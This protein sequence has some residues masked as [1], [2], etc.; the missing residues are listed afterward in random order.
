VGHLKNGIRLSGGRVAK[1]PRITSSA[2][3]STVDL[4]GVGKNAANPIQ[5]S[6]G[7]DKEVPTTTAY[8][9]A[10]EEATADPPAFPTAVASPTQSVPGSQQLGQVPKTTTLAASETT[11]DPPAFQTATASPT[12]SVPGSPQL[13]HSQ[14]HAAERSNMAEEIRGLLIAKRP[15]ESADW[16]AKLPAMAKRFEDKLYMNATS[17]EEYKNRSTFIQRLS[18]LG[19]QGGGSPPSTTKTLHP[20]VSSSSSSSPAAAPP[21]EEQSTPSGEVLSEF[22][23][24]E[25]LIVRLI[26]FILQTI[27]TQTK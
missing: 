1:R 11:A 10:S 20:D 26:L 23:L 14:E 13:W 9:A 21:S 2:H 3:Q 22:I 15:N 17:F 24:A 25:H 5:L 27:S 19:Q 8:D 16:I 12:Q 6:S 18:L 7:A 4:T